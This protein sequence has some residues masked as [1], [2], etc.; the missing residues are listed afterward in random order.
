MME[1]TFELATPADDPAIRRLLATNPIPGSPLV[2]YEREPDYFLGCATIG[3]FCQVLVGRHW[4][5]GEIIGIACRATRS[6]FVNGEAQEIGYLSQLRIDARYRG[7]WLISRGFHALRQLH[8]DKRTAGYLAAITTANAVAQG[9]LVERPRRHFP[10]FR[11]IADIQTLALILRPRGMPRPSDA[12]ERGSAHNLGAI[13]AFLRQQGAA[14]QFFPAY[15]ESDFLENP[16]TRGFK[17][18]DFF[19]ARQRG[20]IVGVIGLWDQSAYKQTVV[21]AYPGWLGRLRPAYNLGTRLLGAQPLPPPGQP[22]RFTYASF[23]CVAPHAPAAFR[24]LLGHVYAIAAA[25]GHAYLM[26]GLVAGDPLLAE[27]RRYAHIAY[28]SR[29]YTVCWADGGG[30]YERLDQRL[31]YAEIAAL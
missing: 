5:G 1:F 11:P 6:L 30:F 15:T 27:A 28:H 10:S 4:P 24:A 13:V 31:P 12:I 23:V 7:R 16:R 25:R 14:R 21:Q 3:S 26:I 29:L 18:E 20:E 8:D 17:V 9:L 19:V 22:I 2:T